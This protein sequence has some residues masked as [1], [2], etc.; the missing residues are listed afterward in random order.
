MPY[1]YARKRDANHNELCDAFRLLGCSVFE[2]DRVGEGFPDIVVGVLG[3][4]ALVELKNPK[5]W[6]GKIGL[7]HAQGKF[8]AAWRG[9][10]VRV[11]STQDDVV[12]LVAELRGLSD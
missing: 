4:N 7:N 1:K 5:S 12:A 9:D 2:T 6:Y 10:R 3:K 8:A 11:V